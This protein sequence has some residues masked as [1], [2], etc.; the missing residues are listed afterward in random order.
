VTDQTDTTPDQDDDELEEYSAEEL[1][2]Q[3]QIN[4][5]ALFLG[6]AESL[7]ADPGLLDS[8]TKSLAATFIRG[9]DT[10]QEW[11]PADILFALVT[12]YQAFGAEIEEA[13]FDADI[14][15][16]TIGNL[17]NVHLAEALEIA[18]DRMDHLFRIGEGLATRL[19]GTLAWNA[20]GHGRIR[21][22]VVEAVETP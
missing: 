2:E 8:W 3:A 10:E 4:A 18:P 6:T 20:E 11:E 16:V 9:W 13:D 1:L 12:N 21:L 22:Q 19:G 15:T 7:S 14:P 5:Q 17:P